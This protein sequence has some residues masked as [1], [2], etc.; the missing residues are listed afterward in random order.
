M[1]M[2][3][4]IWNHTQL[5]EYFVYYRWQLL[6]G[7]DVRNFVRSDQLLRVD[8]EADSTQKKRA[9]ECYKSQTTRYYDWQDRPILTRERVDQVSQAPELLLRYDPNFAGAAVFGTSRAW[10]RFV[11]LVEPRLKQTKEKT[12]TLIRMRTIHDEKEPS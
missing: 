10:I 11:H 9:L 1:Q 5:I 12:L 2:P 6:P 8:I 7:R 4:S 3:P